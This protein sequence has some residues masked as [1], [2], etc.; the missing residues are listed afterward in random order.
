MII[1][2]NEATATAALSRSLGSL[3]LYGHRSG[4]YIVCERP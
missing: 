1:T 4:T 3:N 2:H